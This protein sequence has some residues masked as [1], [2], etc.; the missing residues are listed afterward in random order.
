[1]LYAL[2]CTR[3]AD[4]VREEP[5]RSRFLFQRERERGHMMGRHPFIGCT[6]GICSSN[7]LLRFVV[8]YVCRLNTLMLKQRETS[9]DTLKLYYK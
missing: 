7:V 1:M 5:S 4:T 2:H 3:P 8:A 6:L 9:I